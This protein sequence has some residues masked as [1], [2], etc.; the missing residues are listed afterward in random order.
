MVLETEIIYTDSGLPRTRGGVLVEGLPGIGLVAKVAVAYVLKQLKVEKICRLISPYFPSV[1]FIQDDG[2][3]IFNF[4]DLYYSKQ[5]REV[6][7]LYGNSQPASSYGQ[8]EFCEKVINLAKEM[9]VTTVL[10]IGGYGK[11]SVSERREIY[12]SSTDRE[13]L[14]EWMSKIGGVRY[15]GQ[16]VGAAGLLAVLAKENGMQ[17]FSMLVE[18]AD[19]TPDFYAARRAVEA[20]DKLLNLA[21][22]IPTADELSRTYLTAT[23]ELETF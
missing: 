6:I 5:P 7:L 22:P 14:E 9:G 15:S 11:E 18:T 12:C 1:G 20:L 2:R 16:I 3:M 21:I 10:T 4:A 13:T 23:Q 17:N 8:Y 19:M